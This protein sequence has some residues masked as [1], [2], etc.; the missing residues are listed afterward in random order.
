MSDQPVEDQPKKARRGKGKYYQRTL[1]EALAGVPPRKYFKNKKPVQVIN[2]ETGKVIAPKLGKSNR[3]GTWRWRAAQKSWFKV[4]TDP[5]HPDWTPELQRKHFE[6]TSKAQEKATLTRRSTPRGVRAKVWK[7]ILNERIEQA[8]KTVEKLEYADLIAL[9]DDELERK[10]AKEALAF[11]VAVFQSPELT[12][13]D[14]LT[15]AK[16][17]LDFTKQRPTTKQ[18]VSVKSAEDFLALVSGDC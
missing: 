17:T 8:R 16:I 6:M 10:A 2:P 5:T 14:R 13:K 7:P 9:P 3:P 4:A 15:A 1:E 18:E 12:M 11:N